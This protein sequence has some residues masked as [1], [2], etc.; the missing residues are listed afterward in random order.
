MKHLPTSL[1]P[2][3]L[4]LAAC[5]SPCMALLHLG[6]AATLPAA[7]ANPANGQRIFTQS[8]ASCHDAHSATPKVGIGLQSYYRQHTPRP[9]DVSVRA[10]IQQGKGAMPAFTTLSKSQTDDLIAYLRML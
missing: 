6:S 7:Q 5:V 9:T 8:C 10:I 3:A 4:L 2:A 1:Y